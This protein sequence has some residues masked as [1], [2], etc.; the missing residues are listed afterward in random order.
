MMIV[1]ALFLGL[2]GFVTLGPLGAVIGL[3]VALAVG[4]AVAA[5]RGIFG[6]TAL[7]A[8]ALWEARSIWPMFAIIA[9]IVG[10]GIISANNG[11]ADDTIAASVP[12]SPEAACQGTDHYARCVGYARDMDNL[13]CGDM[14]DCIAKERAISAKYGF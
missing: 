4:V 12:S 11:A 10:V 7:T 3:G 1:L 2:L 5:V 9:L 14:D 13:R 6:V 8:T